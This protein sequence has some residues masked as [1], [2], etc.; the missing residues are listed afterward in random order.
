MLLLIGK[1]EN[2]RYNLIF[3]IEWGSWGILLGKGKL[4]AF[5]AENCIN[6]A[7]GGQDRYNT[8]LRTEVPCYTFTFN[9]HLWKFLIDILNGSLNR[10]IEH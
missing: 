4:T 5:K 2:T 8:Y 6:L 9:Q 1:D 10:Y 3:L 7:R